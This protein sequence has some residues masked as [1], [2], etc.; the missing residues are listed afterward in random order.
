MK[1]LVENVIRTVGEKR[2]QERE[3]D[4]KNEGKGRGG[5]GGE[6][7]TSPKF[8]NSRLKNWLEKGNP[9]KCLQ[10]GNKISSSLQWFLNL[11]KL[12]SNIFDQWI[13]L[14]LG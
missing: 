13:N 7:E 1:T 3:R 11:F 14:L 6:E 12:L 10:E 4:R 9:W 2:E 5:E 8:L